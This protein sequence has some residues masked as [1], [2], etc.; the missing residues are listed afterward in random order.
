MTVEAVIWHV[1][2]KVKPLCFNGADVGAAAATT[3]ATTS[4]PAATAATAAAATATATTTTTTTTTTL[5][6]SNIS[7]LEYDLVRWL[8]F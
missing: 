1:R 6:H 8:I 3:A 7:L 2:Y 5:R 4:A